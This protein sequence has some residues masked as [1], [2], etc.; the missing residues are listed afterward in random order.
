[1]GCRRRRNSGRGFVASFSARLRAFWL[2]F[3]GLCCLLCYQY[4]ARQP[5]SN[6]E[7]S[8]LPRGN[9]SR[10]RHNLVTASCAAK[11]ELPAQ[12]S[13]VYAMRVLMRL[14]AVDGHQIQSISPSYAYF[15]TPYGCSCFRASPNQSWL[16]ST[17]KGNGKC[18]K[19]S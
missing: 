7:I 11:I 16:L 12:S 4:Q 10:R 14:E 13:G 9:G 2:L 19:S 8:A 15:I 6:D 3:S 18:R 17:M 1:M 5:S